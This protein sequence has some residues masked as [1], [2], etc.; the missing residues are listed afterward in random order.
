VRGVFG[1]QQFKVINWTRTTMSIG[2]VDEE[3]KLMDPARGLMFLR[4]ELV[5]HL[6]ECER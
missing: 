1:G 3:A 6:R 5:R 2:G 4:D